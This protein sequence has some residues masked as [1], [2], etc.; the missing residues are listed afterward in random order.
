MEKFPCRLPKP[1]IICLLSALFNSLCSISVILTR[2]MT[3]LPS[4]FKKYIFKKNILASGLGQLVHAT[5]VSISITL[6]NGVNYDD[7]FDPFI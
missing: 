1:S 6:T 7:A 5:Y 2:E 4:T 3:G